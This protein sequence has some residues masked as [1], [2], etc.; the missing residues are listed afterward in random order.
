MQTAPEAVPDYAG[1]AA[2]RP[3]GAPRPPGGRHPDVFP[4][5]SSAESCYGGSLHYR[6]IFLK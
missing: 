3:S 1:A 6:V 4:I 2:E 5:R